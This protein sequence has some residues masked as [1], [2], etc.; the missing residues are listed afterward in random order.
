MIQLG[1]HLDS[2]DKF[3]GIKIMLS[4]I[5]Q[6]AI[7]LQDSAIKTSTGLSQSVTTQNK[8]LIRPSI[9]LLHLMRLFYVVCEDD[10]KKKLLDVI[11]VLEKDL[12]VKNKLVKPSMM[13]SLG[14]S[15]MAD[16]HGSSLAPVFDVA[17]S[18][19]KQVGLPVPDD[20]RAPS[21][22]QIVDVLQNIAKNEAVINLFQ[23]V[24]NSFKK[25]EDFAATATSF[26]QNM[27]QPEAMEGLK[28]SILKTA[29]MA[30]EQ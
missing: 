24:A 12:N 25:N 5:Y 30:K 9:L 21:D 3:K 18:L 23:T 11:G 19:M 20:V 1:E 22:G 4:K 29:D 8:D 28:S 16:G 17:T 26:L 6:S 7:E 13:P 14:P 2:K 15:L 10:D 27:L